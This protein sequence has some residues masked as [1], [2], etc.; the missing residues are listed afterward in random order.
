MMKRDQR[1]EEELFPFYALHALTDEERAEVDAYIAVNPEAAARLAA[2]AQDAAGLALMA[3]PIP[4]SPTVKAVLMARVATD[5]RAAPAPLPRPAARPE[6]ARRRWG[7]WGLA[8]GFAAAVLALI[9]S[10]GAILNINRQNA[11]LETAIAGLESTIAGLQAEMG[12][13][14]TR[15]DELQDQLQAREDQLAAYLAPGAITVAL[16]DITGLHPD[17][18]GT[19]TLHPDDDTATLHVSNLPALD[20]TQTY[21]AWLIAD[22]TPVSAGT[23][24][25]DASGAA[26]HAIGDAAPGSFEAVGVSI[27]PAGGSDQ[28]T[29]DRI[30]L[31]A[32]LT[33]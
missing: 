21:Q 5:S 2:L 10:G 12:T 13:L 19:L 25:V 15:N 14:R 18:V 11:G 23:F 4:P 1:I 33:S 9:I 8:A 16:G 3:T 26:I 6:P 27:E 28:P 31:L 24:N 30:I 17:S 20:E 7:S 29:P 22:G 32:G